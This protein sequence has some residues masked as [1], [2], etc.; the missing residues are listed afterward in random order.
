MVD[1][2]PRT[3]AG[4]SPPMATTRTPSQ[5]RSPVCSSRDRGQTVIFNSSHEEAAF[6]DNPAIA[7]RFL[8]NTGFRDE[9]S[10]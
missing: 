10:P 5:H 4:L 6:W 8:L 7:R 9:S 2:S 1:Y 3:N